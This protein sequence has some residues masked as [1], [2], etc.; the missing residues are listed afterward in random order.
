MQAGSKVCGVVVNKPTVETWQST[1]VCA[2][3]QEDVMIENIDNVD[4]ESAIEYETDPGVE[5]FAYVVL[6]MSADVHHLVDVAEN[7]Y[8]PNLIIIIIQNY[9]IN[10]MVKSK[11]C[12]FSKRAVSL[13]K[14]TLEKNYQ[15]QEKYKLKT[16]IYHHYSLSSILI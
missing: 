1:A 4:H 11:R 2:Q 8:S 16:I 7:N 14:L 6:M 3:F 9:I 10:K 5:D 15:H 12:Y 13:S